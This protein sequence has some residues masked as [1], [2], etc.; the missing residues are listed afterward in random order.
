MLAAWKKSYD[1]YRQHIKKQTH[2]FVDKRP[3]RKSFVFSSSH[4]QIWEVDL[5]ESRELKNWCFWIMVL[6][7]TLEGPLDRKEI[8]PVNPKGNQ[9]WIFIGKT[10]AEVEAPMLWPPDAK[11]RLIGKAPDAG[12]DSRG[13][14]E[15]GRQRMSWLDGIIDSMVMSLSKLWEIVKDR[16]A[17]RAAVHKVAKIQTQLSNNNNKRTTGN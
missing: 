3:Y 5:T 14:E 10:D 7:K 2:H 16:E 13:Q 4:V 12:E 11:I 6:E 15:K 8:K 17:W 9:L 1:K